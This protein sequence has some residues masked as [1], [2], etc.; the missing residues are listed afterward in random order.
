MNLVKNIS[1]PFFKKHSSFATACSEKNSKLYD[2]RLE[3]QQNNM[4]NIFL[5]QKMEKFYTEFPDIVLFV[6]FFFYVKFSLAR[7]LC[8]TNIATVTS[9]QN[10]L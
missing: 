10:D 9:C 4:T 1:I 7:S 8:Y 5:H 2:N 6:L 3:E